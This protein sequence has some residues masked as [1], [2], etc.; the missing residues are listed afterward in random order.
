MKYIL[1]FSSILVLFLSGCNIFNSRKF[2]EDAVQ[3]AFVKNKI[4]SPCEC[5][6]LNIAVKQS[7]KI[8]ENVYLKVFSYGGLRVPK[9]K[10]YV[11]DHKDS[12]IFQHTNLA[13]Y[14][15]FFPHPEKICV[16]LNKQCYFLYEREDGIQ[17]FIKDEKDETI[18]HFWIGN[19]ECVWNNPKFKGWVP[20]P[21]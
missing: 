2:P 7:G 6:K 15:R 1:Y 10:P 20:H 13:S 14:Q 3:V 21:R 5:V 4:S 11:P 17:I 9:I 19:Q 12:L 18:G 8:L 16:L